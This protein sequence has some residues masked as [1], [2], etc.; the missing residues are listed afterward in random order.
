MEINIGKEKLSIGFD[1]LKV[2]IVASILLV[3]AV[4]LLSVVASTLELGFFNFE[5]SLL[6]YANLLSW[7]G[8]LL[9]LLLAFLI[10]ETAKKLGHTTN[11]AYITSM[12]AL[13]FLI[14]L[15]LFAI[16]MIGIMFTSGS[17]LIY[18]LSD[19]IF[20]IIK[21]LFNAAFLYLLLSFLQ[22]KKSISTE[23]IVASFLIFVAPLAI[24]SFMSDYPIIS[25]FVPIA[26]IASLLSNLVFVLII[27]NHVSQEKEKLSVYLYGIGLIF[28]LT[29]LLRAYNAFSFEEQFYAIVTPFYII[30]SYVVGRLL[31]KK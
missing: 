12:S 17:A 8:Y 25:F 9:P 30:A 20:Y 16:S 2:Y 7:S 24:L 6:F 23:V 26:T 19:F 31:I 14:S 27:L 29:F 4:D 10:L 13:V 5:S 3:L 11:G 21:A 15:M 1:H 18:R 28:I 22:N